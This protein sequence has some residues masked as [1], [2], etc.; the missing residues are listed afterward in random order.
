MKRF[1]IGIIGCGRI[2]K[3]HVE[4]IVHNWQDCYLEGVSDILPAQMEKA[5]QNHQQYVAQLATKGVDAGNALNS[6][7][8][9]KY[10]DYQEMLKNANID[11]VAISTESGYHHRIAIDALKAGKHVIVEKP[12]AMSTSDADEMI[13]VAKEQGVKLCVCHQ[14]R[15]NPPI[16]KMRKAYEDGRF[17]RLIHGVA[18][19]RWCRDENYYLQAPW[20]GTW[21]LDGGTLMNQCIHDIDLLQWMMGPVERISAETGRFLRNIEAEDCGVAIL[22][23][24]NGALGIIEGT[25]C[26]FPKNLEETINIF[27]EKGTVCIGGL[28]VNKIETWRFADGQEE[29]AQIIAAQNTADPDTVYGFGHIPL[30]K[31]MFE[32]LRT[33]RE[34]LINGDEGK[35][36]VEIV[37][38]IYKSQRTG[39]TIEFP[40]GDYSTTTGVK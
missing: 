29:E 6:D 38:G 20:R 5:V 27:G 1:G 19:I 22:R 21:A 23:F 7:A 13:C 28:A 39:Q 18:S 11:I 33:G 2:S 4:A 14:N 35:K 30:Y 16:Q 24:K 32:A 37:L 9:N 12:M 3:K 34:P 10:Q 25:A 26:I 31:D 15:F 17:G 40:L 8:I 36:V